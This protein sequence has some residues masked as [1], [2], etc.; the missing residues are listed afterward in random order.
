LEVS[1]LLTHDTFGTLTAA[2]APHVRAGRPNLFI[3][4]PHTKEGLLGIEEATLAGVPINVTLRF[5]RPQ[6]VAAAEAYLPA[7]NRSRRALNIWDS[8][9]LLAG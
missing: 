4:I 5:S 9:S 8:S 3:K 7:G 2:K 6:Y 1:P